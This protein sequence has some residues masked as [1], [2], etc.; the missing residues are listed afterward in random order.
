MVSPD[1]LSVASVLA[2]PLTPGPYFL[3]PCPPDQRLALPSSSYLIPYF[4]ALDKYLDV[5]PPVYFIADHVN[6][7]SRQGQ[8]A[9][10]GRFTTCLDLSIANTLEAE[11]KRP[12][13]SYLANPP[14]VWIDDFLQWLNPVLET[15][16]RVRIDDPNTFCTP[17][18]PER[19]CQPCFLDKDP[20]FDF[21]M[22]GLPEGE[23]FI[24]YLQHWL[25]S[26]TDEECPLGGR[27]SYANA[28]SLGTEKTG[29]GGNRTVVKASHFRTYHTPLKTQEDFIN[30]LAAARRVA[31]D[32]GKRTGAKVYAYSLFYV[33]F[34][35]VRISVIPYDS[36]DRS[37]TSLLC[38]LR[39][40]QYAHI[41]PITVQVLTLALVAVLL[42]TSLLLGSF[43][44]GSLVTLT[45]ALTVFE[46]MG[47]MGVWGISLNAISLVNLVISLGIAVE[48]CSHVARAFM[49]AGGGGLPWG[50]PE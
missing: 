29:D 1:L 39:S 4:D 2:D 34:D 22:N 21:T 20:P 7:S 13:V 32:L 3:E 31:D 12:D 30:A 10:C 16:C 35:Q 15:C 44:T 49:G 47:M 48:F 19:R 27:S 37:L 5:G 14:A 40:D 38:F 18:D 6:V 33:F 36:V 43:R 42:I 8:Q 9:L 50:H 25:E 11:R 41:V 28:V 26:P 23:E 24:R 45:C 17:N 46:V